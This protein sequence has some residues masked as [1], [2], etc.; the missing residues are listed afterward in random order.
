MLSAGDKRSKE[1]FLD[2]EVRC[3][4]F[5]APHFEADV[6]PVYHAMLAR[7]LPLAARLGLVEWFGAREARWDA[8]R[9]PQLQRPEPTPRVLAGSGLESGCAIATRPVSGWGIVRYQK[10][11]GSRVINSERVVH[12]ART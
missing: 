7:E 2:L 11:A 5:G 6:V 9:G 3:E 8:T 4:A 10:S 12:P 1:V